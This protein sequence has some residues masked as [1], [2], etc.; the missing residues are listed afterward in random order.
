VCV[1]ARARARAGFKLASAAELGALWHNQPWLADA[2]H[3]R[4][5]TTSPGAGAI[6][7]IYNST[8][9]GDPAELLV[10]TPVTAV[11]AGLDGWLDLPLASTYAIP[12]GKY[13][14]GWLLEKNQGCFVTA[15]RDLYSINA[16][17][18][19]SAAWGPV[20]PGST[21]I[22]IYASVLLVE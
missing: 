13:W 9:A 10:A 16:W 2:I 8:A 6:G 17:P 7:L 12:P 11:P 22:D 20:S 14:L 15:G 1:C 21:G 19:P 5:N 4:V 18:T 3:V